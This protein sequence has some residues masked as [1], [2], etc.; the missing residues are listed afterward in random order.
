MPKSSNKS[1]FVVNLVINNNNNEMV[2]TAGGPDR[3]NIFSAS[4][5]HPNLW[6][7][8]LTIKAQNSVLIEYI[9]LGNV[10]M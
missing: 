9:N 6:A 8:I 5:G 7:H 1:K 3:V 2:A 10:I 4:G